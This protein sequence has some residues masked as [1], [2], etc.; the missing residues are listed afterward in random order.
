M[1]LRVLVVVGWW[2]MISG[3]VWSLEESPPN[4]LTKEETAEGFRLLFDG[5]SLKGWRGYRKNDCPSGWQVVDGAITRVGPAGDI[6]TE[7]QFGDFEFR[8]QWR[9]DPGANSGVMYH[10]TEKHPQPWNTGP[11]YQILDNKKHRD[12]RDPKTSA[13]A[14]Y[15]LIA[16]SQD[17]TR[18]AGEWNDGMI[19][20]Q[21]GHVEHWLNGVKVLEYQKGSPEWQQ[22]VAASK[23][24]AMPDFGKPTRGHICLQDHG[25]R[26]AYR[27]LRI[28][29]LDARP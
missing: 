9:V 1:T 18:P 8:F 23:F 5:Q 12:G 22:M 19:R 15:G 26:V 20:V 6:V 29:V 11:E 4:T 16:P 7:D 13:A 14:L 28:K 3:A 21:N 27:N 17:V 10:V 2:W 24:K 25:D